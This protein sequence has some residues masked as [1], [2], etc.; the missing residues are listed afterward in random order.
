MLRPGIDRMLTANGFD[1][2]LLLGVSG[3]EARDIM[4]VSVKALFSTVC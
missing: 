1:V 2:N 3:L 4:P